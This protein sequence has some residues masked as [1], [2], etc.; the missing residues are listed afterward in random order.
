MDDASCLSMHTLIYQ[1]IEKMM[2]NVITDMQKTPH[3]APFSSGEIGKWKL[4][5]P[6]FELLI[7]LFRF[8]AH[9]ISL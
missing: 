9:S 7:Q 8:V 4:R 3:S 2:L 6:D 1:Y 5:Q